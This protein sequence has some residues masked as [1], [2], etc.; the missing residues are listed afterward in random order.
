[1]GLYAKF[2]W[3]RLTRSWLKVCVYFLLLLF[4]FLLF[5]SDYSVLAQLGYGLAW[6]DWAVTI[7]I[8]ENWAYCDLSILCKKSHCLILRTIRVLGYSDYRVLAQLGFGLARA[9]LAL[10]WLGL[11]WLGCDNLTGT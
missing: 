1:M 8:E 9:W 11:A 10:A 4:Y 7:L 3:S 2:C 5:N 6:L